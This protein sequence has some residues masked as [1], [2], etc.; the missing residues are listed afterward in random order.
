[1]Q[2]EFLCVVEDDASMERLSKH[3][4]MSQ[5]R[6]KKM[7]DSMEMQ[8]GKSSD[9]AGVKRTNLRS[10]VKVHDG[11]DLMPLTTAD[12]INVLER[13]RAHIGEGKECSLTAGDHEAL[14]LLWALRIC[15][16]YYTFINTVEVYTNFPRKDKST[17][18]T[19]FQSEEMNSIANWLEGVETRD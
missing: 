15:E 19:D 6:Q 13:F 12:K 17:T 11:F 18:S 16:G 10:I 14:C 4:L 3:V 5:H 8:R 9:L 2:K 1:M 7:G